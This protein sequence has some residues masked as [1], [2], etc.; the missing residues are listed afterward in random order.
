LNEIVS[1]EDYMSFLQLKG[2][3]KRFLEGGAHRE[4][5]HSISAEFSRGEYVV[6][7][8][9]SGSGKTTLLNV[10]SGL[11]RPDDGDIL[12]DGESLV[13][14]GERQRTLFRR[15]NIGF[16]FQFFNLVPTL[17][18]WENVTL[19]LELNGI[20]DDAGHKRAL[21]L[22][23][24]VELDDRL[25]AF[26]DRLSGG[27]Q[28]RVAIARAL[29]H[30]PVLLLADEPTGNLDEATGRKILALLEN[31]SRQEGKTLLMVSHNREV[32]KNVDRVFTLRKGS[33]LESSS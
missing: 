33:L 13:N 11:E 29:V 32:T 1:K 10:I 23:H 7:L 12:F 26:S 2:V 19:P 3:S 15:K 20:M 24:N 17:T 25:K 5:L 27:E 30:D 18:V 6:I 16:I 21:S 8:G 22:L 28:Q 14:W 9:K 4:V 31:L